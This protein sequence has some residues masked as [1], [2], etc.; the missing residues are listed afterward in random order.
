MEPYFSGIQDPARSVSVIWRC[1]VPAPGER[2]WPRP[3]DV[4]AIDVPIWELR[5]A[6]EDQRLTRLAPDRISVETAAKEDLRPG[7][8]VVLPTEAGLLDQ[9]GWDATCQE[10]AHDVALESAGL[11]LDA[12]AI[13]RL[14]NVEVGGLVNTILQNDVDEPDEE[15][16]S[17]ALDQ[18]IETLR[19]TL[20]PKWDERSWGD[21]LSALGPAVTEAANE[22]PRLRRRSDDT[23]Q[24]L[25]DEF[26]ERSLAATAV[27]LHAHGE[28]V[29]AQARAVAHRIGLAGDLAEVLRLSGL[30]HD[31]GK[32]DDRF[33]QW[34]RDGP[35]TQPLVAKSS[36]RR[37]RWAAARVAAGW[38]RRRSAR[39]VVCP[40][41]DS[42]AGYRRRQRRHGRGCGAVDTLGRQSPWQRPAAGGTGRRRHAVVGLLVL[43]WTRSVGVRRL[44]SRRLGAAGALCLP[45]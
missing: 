43:Q 18:L 21:F 8:S 3:R 40:A 30:C 19:G 16:S 14:A 39:G 38:P 44:G 22:V 17:A 41:G 35:V 26:D 36:M 33:Q 42:V 28:A 1:H 25:Y 12:V 27:E 5:D 11:P 32:A 34:L 24:V 31:V 37:D 45:Q 7:D 20:P 15:E 29:G 10:H 13:R 9:F 23:S 2:L 6:L 4:E